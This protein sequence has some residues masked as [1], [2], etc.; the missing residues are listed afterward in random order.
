M[1][2]RKNPLENEPRGLEGTVIDTDTSKKL[3]T[4]YVPKDVLENNI[5]SPTK[6]VVDIPH[7][8][9]LNF[10]QKFID[11]DGKFVYCSTKEEL[12]DKLIQFFKIN[13]LPSVFIWEDDIVAMIRERV[14]NEGI[15]VERMP[16]EAHVALSHCEYLVSDEGTIILTPYQNQFRPLENF[17]DFHIVI[18]S[19]G[20]VKLNIDH[21]VSDF[22]LKHQAVFP[23]IIDISKDDKNVRFVMN[24]PILLSRGTK[25]VFVFYCEECCF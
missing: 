12:V 2:I 3:Y 7:D 20:Q 10:A 14:I 1:F 17:P 25:K 24:K 19:K 4:T 16:D 13:H 22:I 5:Y 18:A 11:K 6:S 15:K 23:F 21:A 9:D 8:A